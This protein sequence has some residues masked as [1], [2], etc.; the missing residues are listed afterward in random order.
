VALSVVIPVYG[1]AAIFPSLHRR[2]V[3]VLDTLTDAWEIIGVVDGS[4]D[5]SAAVIAAIHLRDP[6]VKLIEFSRNF[7]NQMAITAGLRH[8]AGERVVVMDDDLEDPPELIPALVSRADEGYDVVYAVRR[9][10]NISA[11]RALAIRV[12]NRVFRALSD[13]QMTANVGDFCLMSRPVVDALNAMPEGHRFVRALRTWAGFSQTGVEYDREPRHAGR[14]GFTFGGYLGLGLDGLLSFSAAPLR[15]ATGLGLVLAAL[16]FLLATLLSLGKL[17]GL[18]PALPGWAL[19]T[20]WL[21]VVLG[22]Q[23]TMIG[24]LG[25]YVGRIYDEVRQRPPYIIRRSLGFGTG[26]G[27]GSGTEQGVEF[28]D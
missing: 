9:S 1:S 24:V 19:A 28:V 3:D 18:A 6:R 10:R 25:Q 26:E 20:A 2:L 21:T 11:R 4:G 7:G 8:A 15:A 22:V 5:D 13:F 16:S 12:Y 23:M 27:G 17:A 14:S